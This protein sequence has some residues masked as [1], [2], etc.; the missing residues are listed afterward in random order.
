MTYIK[1]R[2]RLDV[3]QASVLKQAQ[4]LHDGADGETLLLGKVTD[5]GQTIAWSKDA[6]CN[7]RAKLVSQL[8]I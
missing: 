7:Q 8:L 2:L 3:Y 1:T 5:R 4:R 6:A